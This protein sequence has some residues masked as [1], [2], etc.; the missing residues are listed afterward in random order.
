[1]LSGPLHQIEAVL[2]TGGASTRMGA[3]KAKLLVHGEPMGDR[4]ARALSSAGYPVTVCGNSPIDGFAF[5]PDAL[6]HAGPLAAVVQFEPSRPYVFLA[7]CDLPRFDAR[8]AE[9]LLSVIGSAAA[10]VPVLEGNRQPL[11]ALYRA[12]AFDAAKSA[13][14]SGKRSMMAWLDLLEVEEVGADRLAA[15]GI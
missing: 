13:F 15:A 14:A 11:T 7:A 6:P 9:F 10:G 12:D 5:L 4:T 3:D 1:M 8:I 2:L